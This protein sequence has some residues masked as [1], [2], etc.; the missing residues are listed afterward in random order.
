MFGFLY[1]LDM[2]WKC[3]KQV[4]LE[5]RTVLRKLAWSGSVLKLI[6]K[7][8]DFIHLTKNILEISYDEP[9]KEAGFVP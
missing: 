9:S 4:V 3:R 5:L 7:I 1:M 8:E 2:L 6:I